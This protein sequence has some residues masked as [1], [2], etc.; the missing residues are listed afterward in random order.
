VDVCQPE[1]NDFIEPL[2]KQKGPAGFPTYSIV[3]VKDVV[4]SAVYITIKENTEI[5]VQ[6]TLFKGAQRRVVASIS[7]SAHNVFVERQIYPREVSD[8]I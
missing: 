3:R 1:T 2:S 8:K 4:L 6:N 5:G 7:G